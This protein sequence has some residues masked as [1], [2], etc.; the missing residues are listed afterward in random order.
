M[1]F[2]F[3]ARHFT[4]RHFQSL[5]SGITGVEQA[6]F[7]NDVISAS[8]VSQ[9][10]LDRP[11]VVVPPLPTG[12]ATGYGYYRRRSKE[13]EEE[14]QR[15][16]EKR[17]ER[18]RDLARVIDRAIAKAQGEIAGDLPEAA[19][20]PSAGPTAPELE[21]IDDGLTAIQERVQAIED[22]G[23]R[24][25]EADAELEA[26]RVEAIALIREAELDDDDEALELLLAA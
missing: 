20:V 10:M 22:L 9:P 14:Y 17:E 11:E 16:R 18:L 19:T 15:E 24:I 12:P 21:A 6:L 8:F 23:G 25:L 3:R 26:L 2:H 7:A 4:A 1:I 13:D 5:N